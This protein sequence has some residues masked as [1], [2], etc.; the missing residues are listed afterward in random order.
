MQDGALLCTLTPEFTLKR[1]GESRMLTETPLSL[2]REKHGFC[3]LLKVLLPCCQVTRE[4]GE[5]PSLRHLQTPDPRPGGG[6][7][8][9]ILRA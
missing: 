3:T 8:M 2:Q 9:S 5:S 6:L 4:T 1:S 7:F